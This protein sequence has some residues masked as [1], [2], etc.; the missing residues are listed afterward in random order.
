[1]KYFLCLAISQNQYFLL[2]TDFTWSHHKYG[3]ISSYSLCYYIFLLES[4]E[5][6]VRNSIWYTLFRCSLDTMMLHLWLSLK[7]T[8]HKHTW[9]C[10]YARCFIFATYELFICFTVFNLK[11][12]ANGMEPFWG[13]INLPYDRNTEAMWC[14]RV[15]TMRHVSNAACINTQ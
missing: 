11:M 8:C 12:I 9:L 13:R 7:K 1:M 2:P 10:S 4:A 3:I 6:T 15:L 5:N 14:F